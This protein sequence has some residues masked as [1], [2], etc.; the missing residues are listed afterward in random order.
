MSAMMAYFMSRLP[1]NFKAA[2]LVL[3]FA[4][5]HIFFFDKVIQARFANRLS[6]G[7]QFILR[8][9]GNQFHASIDQIAHRPRHLESGG[10]GFDVVAKPNAL[11]MTAVNNLHTF[12][13]HDL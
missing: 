4:P 12:A 1:Y 11:D 8:T 3:G 9:L 5:D 6:E 7:F 13:I 10:H 2:E